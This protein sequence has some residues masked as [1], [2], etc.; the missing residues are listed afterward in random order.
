VSESKEERSDKD[1]TFTTRSGIAVFGGSSLVAAALFVASCAGE[2][3]APEEAEG[4]AQAA[5]NRPGSHPGTSTGTGQSIT[6]TS[7]SG[8]STGNAG[9][10][11]GEASG[12]G[13]QTVQGGAGS[14]PAGTGGSGSTGSGGASGTGGTPGTGG[15]GGSAGGSTGT[16]PLKG[17]AFEYNANC[18]DLDRLKV[19]W[20][21]N[22][23]SSTRC[24]VQAEYVPQ[25]A[26]NWGTST[27]AATPAKVA[28]AGFKTILGFNEPDQAAQ[29]NMSVADVLKAWPSFNQAS[30]SRVGSPATSSSDQGKAW[31][32]QFMT[33][34]QQQGLRVDF[35]ALHWYGWN[36][37]S[38]TPTANLLEDYIKWAEQ[39]KKPLWITEWSCHLQSADVS[40]AF[41]DGAIAMFKRHPLVERYAWFLSRSTGEFAGAAL[42][43]ANGNPTALGQDYIAA[44]AYH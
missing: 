16:Q 21:Y 31:F 11:L 18:A 20:Y 1:M 8:G 25:V 10:D 28:A 2:V 30:F 22:W 3:S 44:P 12:A 35:I 9:S 41:Y 40:K 32:A 6:T 38:C 33:G 26:R 34:V 5:G 17:L 23:S 36:A 24:N 39:W 19:S 37:G 14:G 4:L 15:A 13:G 29:A 27:T 43:D 42:L 7:G